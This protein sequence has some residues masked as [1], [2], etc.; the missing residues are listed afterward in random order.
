M[1]ATVKEEGVSDVGAIA[2]E[3]EG[4]C[5]AVSSIPYVKEEE[6]GVE[7]VCPAGWT[8][9]GK[10]MVADPDK[11]LEYFTSVGDAEEEFGAKIQVT[12]SRLVLRCELALSGCVS[13]LSPALRARSLQSFV[14]LSGI[15]R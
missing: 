1:A 11:S 10:T 2:R 4:V 6:E 8:P 9:G 14:K 13:L 12:A 3:D 5:E 7:Q 15:L